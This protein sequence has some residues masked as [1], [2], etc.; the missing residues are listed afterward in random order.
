MKETLIYGIPIIEKNGSFRINTDKIHPDLYYRL[1]RIIDKGLMT[2]DD[3]EKEIEAVIN[4]KPFKALHKGRECLVSPLFTKGKGFNEHEINLFAVE[5]TYTSTSSNIKGATV[6]I[7]DIYDD[8]EMNR[9][10]F[11]RI[12]SLEE[13]KSKIYD[14]I[15]SLKL[16]ITYKEVRSKLL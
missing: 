14:A 15:N 12:R 2:S 11:S 7:F 5:V 8:T 10:I 9:D 13:A 1:R 4:F 6:D 16:T 3:L